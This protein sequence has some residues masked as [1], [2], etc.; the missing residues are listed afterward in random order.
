MNPT[1]IALLSVV[2]AV[3]TL[4]FGGGAFLTYLKATK[5]QAVLEY[6]M[7]HTADLVADCIKDIVTLTSGLALADQRIGQIGDR[8]KKL[9]ILETVTVQLSTLMARTE[10]IL[11]RP[12]AE[13]KFTDLGRRVDHVEEAV[14]K[15]DHSN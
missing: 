8:L 4:M 9:D 15:L 11:P 7:N 5:A 6:R 3:L 12:E 13:A 1:T 2:V 10:N 14:E